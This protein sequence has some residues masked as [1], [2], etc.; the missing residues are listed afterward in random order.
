M[1][2]MMDKI[3]EASNLSRAV[4]K[5]RKNHGAAGVDGMGTDQL[6]PFFA[7]NGKKIKKALRNGTYKPMPVRQV[8][9]PKPD[10]KKRTLGIPTVRDRVIQQAVL[11]IL[12]PIYEPRF[13]DASYGYRPKRNP[14]GAVLKCRSYL[15]DGYVWAVDLDVEQFFD[16]VNQQ[17]IMKTLS[18]TVRDGRLLSLVW[19]TMRAGAIYRGKFPKT[20]QGVP[21]GGPLSPLLANILLDRLD[22]ELERTGQK[23]VRYADDMVILCK[24]K[25]EAKNVLRRVTGFL[26][27]ELRL[28]INRE[29]TAVVYANK[30]QFLGFGFY[31]HGDAFRLR[32]HPKAL[33]RMKTRIDALLLACGGKSR[34]AWTQ[35]LRQ[36]I[37]G[38]IGYYKLADL[39]TTLKSV[40]EYMQRQFRF[41]IKAL[42]EEP[43]AEMQAPK[44]KKSACSVCGAGTA[45]LQNG[46]FA[47]L[48]PLLS[49]R[50]LETGGFPFFSA[51]YAAIAG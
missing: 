36:Y 33:R 38:W 30:I 23:F 12:T 18:K 3:L 9:I 34:L 2:D 13:S 51:H 44:G 47:E 50:Q 8:K 16:T 26:E 37:R 11:Q 1:T 45:L 27:N 4:C 14:Q 35:K 40:D 39:D 20:R 25:A 19:K 46:T 21:Q 24:S 49:K 32:V 15:N 7:A 31:K 29:K 22:K 42:W 41:R 17:K 10:G 28:K 43:V 5:V 48:R 6:L